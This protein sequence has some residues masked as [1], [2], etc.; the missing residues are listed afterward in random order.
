MIYGY[1]IVHHETNNDPKDAAIF[2]LED[3]D[4]YMDESIYD[5]IEEAE[6]QRTRWLTKQP[7]PPPGEELIIALVVS[8]D[9]TVVEADVHGQ[10]GFQN[11]E[12]PGTCSCNKYPVPHTHATSL[13]TGNW[14]QAT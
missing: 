3:Y 7:Y 2:G 12:I 13:S 9:H 8:L 1:T 11:R 6:Q 10:M 5:T 4:I 14:P